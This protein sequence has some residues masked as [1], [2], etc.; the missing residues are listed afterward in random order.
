MID[1]AD[2]SAMIVNQLTPRELQRACGAI[3]RLITLA[4]R[5]QDCL[6]MGMAVEKLRL[7][8]ERMKA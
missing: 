1:L 5:R 7:L 3:A 8:R 6:L 4:G 2:N